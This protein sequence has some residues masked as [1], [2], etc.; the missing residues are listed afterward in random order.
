MTATA[1]TILTSLMCADLSRR[2]V[3]LSNKKLSDS[4]FNLLTRSNTSVSFSLAQSQLK[5]A[6][7]FAKLH[8]ID[9]LSK[10]KDD[11]DC[12]KNNKDKDEDNDD[13]IMAV[14]EYILTI[15]RSMHVQIE[16]MNAAEDAYLKHKG[17]WFASFWPVDHSASLTQLLFLNQQ[18]DERLVFISHIASLSAILQQ[19]TKK[20]C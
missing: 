9:L 20:T 19:K 10:K 12:V 14:M 6:G 3:S 2:A 11:D 5:H 8:I 7:I 15:Q 4:L 1:V 18:L 16:I 17:G 13:F